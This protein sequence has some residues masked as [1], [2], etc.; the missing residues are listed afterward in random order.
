MQEEL[1]DIEA[2]LKTGKPVTHEEFAKLVTND[3]HA[4]FAF[5]IKN[6]PGS[7]NNVL[8]NKLHY[9]HELSFTPDIKKMGRVCDIILERNN[10]GEIETILNNF[11][12]DLNK[13]SPK[14]LKAIHSA[15]K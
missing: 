2:R 8:M 13:I 12:F 6:N 9:T 10:T 5:M 11:Q 3:K 14:L 1:K 15:Q 7:M 4:F